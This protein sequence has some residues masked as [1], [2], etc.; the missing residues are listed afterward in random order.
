MEKFSNKFK[1][2]FLLY[3][4][5]ELILHSASGE[6]LQLKNLMKNQIQEE[7]KEFAHSI[8]F[9][10]LM[11]N[12]LKE[13]K[14]QFIHSIKKSIPGKKEELKR[15]D[16]NFHQIFKNMELKPRFQRRRLIIPESKLPPHLQYL[17]PIAR[18]I[19][20]DL[21]KLNS[22][23]KDPAVKVIKCGGP[24]EHISVSGSMGVKPTNTVLNKEEIDNV[25]KKFSKIS[26]I[27]IQE[28]IYSVVVGRLILSAIIS[29]VVG[30]KFIIKKML[31]TPN[32]QNQTYPNPTI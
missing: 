8:K 27:P 23:I 31:Y 14:K 16:L 25:I 19:K 10:T 15:E 6:I 28:G 21:E 5:K 22:L 11:N 32:F 7:K 3:F 17:K 29:E 1:K 18:E 2:L 26:K 12:Q 13:E 20:I 4:T 30:S 24:D 9:Q